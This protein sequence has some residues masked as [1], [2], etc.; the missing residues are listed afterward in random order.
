MCKL[1]FNLA[2]YWTQ[3]VGVVILATTL[4]GSSVGPPQKR[5]ANDETEVKAV[6]LFNFAQFVEWNADAL[7]PTDTPIVIG[8]IGSDPFGLYLDETVRGEAVNGHPFK[9]RRYKSPKEIQGC[10]ILFINP[11]RSVRLESVLKL[12]EG[13]DI[14]TVSDAPNFAK[15]GGMIQFLNQENKIRLRIKLSAVRE[16]N[17][18]ISS[19]LLSLSEV[20]E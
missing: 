17:I 19:K 12:V 4:M 10:H 11:D 9:I 13:Q 8:I 16:S 14:L 15:L 2:T 5:A 20:I 7:P 6:F 1:K 3:F 18:K